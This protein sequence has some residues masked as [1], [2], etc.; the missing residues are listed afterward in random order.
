M[1]TRF[2][3]TCLFLLALLAT[4]SESYAGRGCSAGG[5]NS[6]GSG[7]RGAPIG[8]SPAMKKRRLAIAYDLGKRIL[9]GKVALRPPVPA[10]VSSQELGLSKFKERAPNERIDN[11]T[12][13][14]S[15]EEMSAVKHYL[16]TRYP[17]SPLS[18][19]EIRVARW[20]REK[21]LFE[22]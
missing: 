1:K 18:A 3:V 8:E 15:R 10:L 22:E 12:G 4:P 20:Q 14:L 7:P 21:A 16:A 6:G 11:V 13:R 5:G 2:I 9:E 17:D 19:E